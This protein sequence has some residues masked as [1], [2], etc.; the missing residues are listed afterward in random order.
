MPILYKM[1]I[2]N[3]SKISSTIQVRTPAIT[4]N[5]CI[6]YGKTVLLRVSRGDWL[7]ASPVDQ[8]NQE[9][10][11]FTTPGKDTNAIAKL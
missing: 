7:E 9:K 4:A 5:I 2:Q 10:L 8:Y 1:P 6:W 3:G 11:S